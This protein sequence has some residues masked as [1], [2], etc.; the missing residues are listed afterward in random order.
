MYLTLSVWRARANTVYNK[1]LDNDVIR[2]KLLFDRYSSDTYTINVLPQDVQETIEDDMFLAELHLLVNL[3]DSCKERLRIVMTFID[4][5][6]N[7]QLMV[8]RRMLMR[9][10]EDTR[11]ETDALGTLSSIPYDC[12]WL[13]ADHVIESLIECN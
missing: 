11:S 1:L 9:Y 7:Q 3:V 4:S 2:A 5:Y 10:D 8:V 6:N 12:R 13:I